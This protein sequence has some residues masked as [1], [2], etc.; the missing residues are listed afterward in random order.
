MSTS[1]WAYNPA[2]C[3]GDYCTGDCEICNKA[4]ESEVEAD[5]DSN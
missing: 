1:K 5:A 3:D 2:K 4:D